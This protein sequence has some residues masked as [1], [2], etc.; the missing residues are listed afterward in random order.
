VQT[1]PTRVLILGAGFGGLELSTRLSD[2]LGDEV[3][4]TLV[5]QS[6]AFVFGFSKL[7]VMF[8]RRTSDEVRLPYRDIT[9]PGVE[10]RQ[11]TVVSIDPER[12]RVV[13]NARTYDADVLVVALG[14]DL[15]PAATP[16]LVEGGYEFYSPEGAARVR[17]ILPGFDAGVAVIAV[18]GGLF[19][20]PPA[21]FET[22]FL[23]HDLLSRRGVDDAVSIYIVSPLPI[24]IPI[25]QEVS[26]AILALL[27]ARRIEYWGGS[28]VTRLDPAKKTAHLQDGR[29]LAY[30][31]FLGIPV[32]RAPAVVLESGLAEDGWIPVD[33]ATFATRFPDVYA[34]G[35]VTSA[36]VPRAGVIAEG[37]A[38]TVADVLIA[39]LG[40]GAAPG[41]Y[42]GTATCYLELGDDLVGRVDVDFF[43][44]PRPSAAFR[45]P[46]SELADEKRQF[47]ASRRRRWFGHHPD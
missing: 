18:L 14:A 16:G 7:D 5:D 17:E 41:P 4:V 21:P 12:K 33:P 29:Q 27:A 47:G 15:D 6:D 24:P 30:D 31:L 34:V 36:P 44:G 25:S 28:L 2:A 3:Q 35:D 19:K 43:S 46:S 1:V 20:C 10:F 38:V 8:G 11:E 9:K 22:A 13:T 45:P 23:L 42:H 32:H 39:K 26:D 37:E 40:G